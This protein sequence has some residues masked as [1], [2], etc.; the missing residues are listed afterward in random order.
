[1]LATLMISLLYFAVG[2]VVLT[3]GVFTLQNNTNAPIN[4]V[5]FALTVSVTIWSAG[6][7]FTLVS[8]NAS[9][10]RNLL[11]FLGIRMVHGLCPSASL[12]S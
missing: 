4:R 12:L 11:A 1:M 9:G 7:G 2:T 6:I 8:L 5:F 10:M 3:S